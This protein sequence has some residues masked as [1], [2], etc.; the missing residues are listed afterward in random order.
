MRETMR[1]LDWE[2]VRDTDEE[3]REKGR[4][5]TREKMRE[6]EREYELVLPT[7]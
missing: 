2:S 7:F 1:N 3:T 5:K 4:E 6:N